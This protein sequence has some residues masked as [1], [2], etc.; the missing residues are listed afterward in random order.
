MEWGKGRIAW[1]LCIGHLTFLGCL[2]SVCVE[3][4]YS[5]VPMSLSK[6]SEEN[7]VCVLLREQGRGEGPVIEWLDTP[8]LTCVGGFVSL[9]LMD[10]M[11]QSVI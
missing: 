5:W 4:A 3:G 9:S 10:L 7:R 8:L 1:H 2:L 11:S 6:H